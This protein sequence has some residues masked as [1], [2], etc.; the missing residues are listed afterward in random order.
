MCLKEDAGRSSQQNVQVLLFPLLRR[1]PYNLE[2]IFVRGKDIALQVS[3]Q[4]RTRNLELFKQKCW[5][6]GCEK[7]RQTKPI[8]IFGN[9]SMD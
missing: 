8:P 4:Q 2:Q 6:C 1:A 7:V 5:E 3:N 9:G